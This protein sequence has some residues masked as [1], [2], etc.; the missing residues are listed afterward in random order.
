MIGGEENK[1]TGSGS[2]RGWKLGVD[3]EYGSDYQ[4]PHEI[5]SRGY[6]WQYWHSM[7]EWLN[8]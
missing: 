6:G 3:Y 7:G 5:P 4:W 8:D 1:G 2:F